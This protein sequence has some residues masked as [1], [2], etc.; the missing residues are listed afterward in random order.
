LVLPSY[1]DF[2]EYKKDQLYIYPFHEGLYVQTL[3]DVKFHLAIYRTYLDQ[4]LQK[5]VVEVGWFAIVSK[6]LRIIFF[7]CCLGL[8]RH[9]EMNVQIRNRDGTIVFSMH[10]GILWTVMLWTSALAYCVFCAVVLARAYRSRTFFFRFSSCN[11]DKGVTVNNSM[12]D[13]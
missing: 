5:I 1:C 6:L 10:L 12:Y 4:L 7:E 9:L 3:V 13:N 8:E 11:I 2:L